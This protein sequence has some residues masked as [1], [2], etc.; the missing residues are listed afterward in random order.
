MSDTQRMPR[1]GDS[2]PWGRIDQAKTL[3]DGIVSVSTA[4]HGGIRLSSELNDAMPPAFKSSDCW[5]EEDCDWALVAL[6]HPE[7]FSA[8]QQASAHKTA[9]NWMPEA[10]EAWSGTILQPGESHTKDHRMFLEQH[11]QEWLVTTAFGSWH[12]CVP[13]G[14]VGVYAVKGSEYE[15]RTV[16]AETRTFLVPEDDYDNRKGGIYICDPAKLSTWHFTKPKSEQ[17]L[18][19]AP[20]N[21]ADQD[22][23]E[24]VERPRP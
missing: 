9:K 20:T 1:V 17:V 12:E 22:N 24:E 13:N 5:Y 7:A 18:D 4:S 23:D 10:Y 6:I 2:S 14:Y 16:A 11:A 3:A 19:V 8:N 15:M 21:A